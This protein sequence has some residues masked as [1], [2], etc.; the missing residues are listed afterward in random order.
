MNLH[1]NGK[2]GQK[3]NAFFVLQNL[4]ISILQIGCLW[5]DFSDMR[6]YTYNIKRII[7][8]CWVHLDSCYEGATQHP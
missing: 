8:N 7:I 1:S 3:I 2:Y 5:V 4:A 6:V